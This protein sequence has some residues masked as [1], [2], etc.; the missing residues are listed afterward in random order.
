M[1]RSSAVVVLKK[2]EALAYYLLSGAFSEVTTVTLADAGDSDAY[3]ENFYS[4]GFVIRNV[5]KGALF[6]ILCWSSL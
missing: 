4:I 5:E 2:H 3:S 1:G 6:H